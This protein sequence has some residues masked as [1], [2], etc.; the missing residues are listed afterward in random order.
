MGDLIVKS[1]EEHEL[2]VRD[3]FKLHS[4]AFFNK[5]KDFN[6]QTFSRLKTIEILKKTGLINQIIIS[7]SE[8]MRDEFAAYITN[9]SNEFVVIVID[10]FSIPV[11]KTKILE[12]AATKWLGYAFPFNW[13]E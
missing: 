2:L 10:R 12:D 8:K 6:T 13:L 9:K 3:I 1:R 5:Y 7:E 11:Y 4:E